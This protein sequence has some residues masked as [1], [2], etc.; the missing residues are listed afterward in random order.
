[1][2][3]AENFVIDSHSEPN[4]IHDSGRISD[5]TGVIL[6]G[7]ASRRMGRNKALMKI[8]GATLIERVYR[9][10]AALF[11]DV[12]IVTNTPQEYAFIPCRKVPDIYPGQGSIAGLHAGL[13]SSSTQRV[14][15]AACDMPFL[16]PELIRLLCSAA[17]ESDAVIP[18][19][20]EGLR[21]PLHALY[22]R[23]TLPVVQEIIEQ[24]DKSILILLDRVRTRLVTPEGYCSIAGAEESF[25][26]VNTP[27]EFREVTERLR[28]VR[29]A[30][31]ASG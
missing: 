10:L 4:T 30:C 25:R 26:N 31:G 14:F 23:T 24:G 28:A 18:L 12:I 16:N 19:N 17:G 21:E 20:R 3:M 9:T 5:V 29:H 2:R 15:I 11:S 22:T 1:M 7:G 6:A 13:F 8:G 27:E